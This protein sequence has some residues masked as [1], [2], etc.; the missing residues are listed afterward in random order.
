M[1]SCLQNKFNLYNHSLRLQI[2]T[3]L[4][5]FLKNPTKSKYTEILETIGMSHDPLNAYQ[6]KKESGLS[7][8]VYRIIDELYPTLRI[9]GEFLFNLHDIR[10]ENDNGT[11][12]RKLIKKIGKL[13]S[14]ELEVSN[15]A[16]AELNRK[17]DDTSIMFEQKENMIWI[18][19]KD[20]YIFI[21]V[22]GDDVRSFLLVFKNENEKQMPNKINE[23]N[24]RTGK[25]KKGEISFY[26]EKTEGYKP[27]FLKITLSEKA[28]KQIADIQDRE[29]SKN[30]NAT[31]LELEYDSEV[32]RIKNDKKNWRYALN[33]RGLMLYLF[34]IAEQKKRINRSRIRKV[35]SNPD[36]LSDPNSL[37]E[38][39]PFL[40]RWRVLEENKFHVVDILLMISKEVSQI[41]N[42]YYYHHFKGEIYNDIRLKRIVTE[43]YFAEVS[44]F[45]GLYRGGVAL[46]RYKEIESS[47]RSKLEEY[48]SFILSNQKRFL[49]TELKEVTSK[50]NYFE[51]SPR[52]NLEY[53][54]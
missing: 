35:L 44:D 42:S 23:I 1:K 3:K 11:Y 34:G 46:R 53:N 16:D 47:E 41:L 15:T 13:C 36:L 19:Y 29:R 8:D 30:L 38:D 18:F 50:L 31:E 28:Q 43:R 37:N 33:L 27:R 4:V 21:F 39:A 25:N 12:K 32:V 17:E 40:I 22:Y 54:K 7:S 45:F 51:K 20:L 49:E 52:S 26:G 2:S 10:K 24:I 48:F 6:I 5:N 9:K 14:I